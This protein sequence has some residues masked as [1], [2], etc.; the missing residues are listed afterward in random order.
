MEAFSV[1][2]YISL[3]HF[4]VLLKRPREMILLLV[5]ILVFDVHAIF[6]AY[7][8]PV[9]KYIANLINYQPAIHLARN[10]TLDFLAQQ[11]KTKQIAANSPR[12]RDPNARMVTGEYFALFV[13]FF[14][15]LPLSLSPYLP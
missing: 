14:N 12:G 15:H 5:K 6:K 1:E 2:I 3:V 10:G 13:I 8:Y 9:E 7:N 11:T 4:S